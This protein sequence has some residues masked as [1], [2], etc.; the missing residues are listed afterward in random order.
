[1]AS[2][3]F[4]GP[5]LE[6]DDPDTPGAGRWEINVSSQ[7]EKRRDVWEWTPLLD[8]NYGA[9][10][11]V[12]LKLKPR[13]AI[14]DEPGVDARSGPGNI[15]LGIKWRFL[16]ESSNGVAMSVYPQVDVN[17]PGDS[18][19]RGLVDVGADFILPAQIARSFGRTRLYGEI[20]AFG[21][22]TVATGGFTASLSNTRSTVRC[23]APPKF[24]AAA[25]AL[26]PKASCS[27]TSA[28]KSASPIT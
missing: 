20:G 6:P 13:Y 25:K 19:R 18:D 11:R 5:P 23:A 8:I 17:P 9:G 2:S 22:S 14:L 28:S 21:A 12:Q 3:A 7:L 24:A 10:E 16:D 1:M 15:Q 27:S 26:S 4:A